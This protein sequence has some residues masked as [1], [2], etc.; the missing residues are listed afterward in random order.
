MRSLSALLFRSDEASPSPSA[1]ASRLREVAASLEA[2]SSGDCLHHDVVA[3]HA[4]PARRKRSAGRSEFDASRY[5]QRLV[6]L[7]VFYAGWNYHGFATQGCAV[8]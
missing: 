5:P 4:L 3:P 6:A 8:C 2:T 1:L 7:E